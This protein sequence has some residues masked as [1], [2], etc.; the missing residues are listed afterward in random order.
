MTTREAL[1]KKEKKNNN[2][3]YHHDITDSEGTT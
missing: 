3:N 2:K 1:F